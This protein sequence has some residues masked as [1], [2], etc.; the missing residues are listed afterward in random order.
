MKRLG[1]EVLL[2]EFDK[3]SS[4]SKDE[5]FED[6]AVA[7]SQYCD[8]LVIRHSEKEMVQRCAELVKIPS[9]NAGNGDGEHPTQALLDVFTIK[10]E[11]GRLN[12][13]N[14]LLVGD[15]WSGRTIHSL[16]QL[17]KLYQGV[18][19]YLCSPPFMCL[20]EEYR[21][22]LNIMDEQY[23]L[24]TMLKRHGSSINVLYMT[25]HQ[26][27]RR[28]GD[29]VQTVPYCYLGDKEQSYLHHEMKIMHP[30]PRN[31][32]IPTE[33]DKE[34]QA[35]YFRQAQN[36]MYVRMALLDN[37]FFKGDFFPI[38]FPPNDLLI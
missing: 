10:E 5:S 18:C 9:I 15:L 31:Q 16:V 30:L 37:V 35:A 38:P 14:I 2:L 11:I 8:A 4:A 25:R 21:A 27:E 29:S 7:M 6:T 19:V 26:K 17:L 36:G 24:C 22:G 32:E 13:Y 33:L 12:N 20:P 1:G 34:P 23:D 3:N 28:E